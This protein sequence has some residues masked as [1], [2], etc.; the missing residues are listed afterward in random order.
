MSQKLAGQGDRAARLMTQ[1]FGMLLTALASAQPAA[2]A[3]TLKRRWP[4]PKVRPRNLMLPVTPAR[5]PA[6]PTAH[7][8]CRRASA[9][10]PSGSPFVHAVSIFGCRAAASRRHVMQAVEQAEAAR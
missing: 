1:A 5:W 6:M 4:V 10:L 9:L 7:A 8:F 3:G 2:R